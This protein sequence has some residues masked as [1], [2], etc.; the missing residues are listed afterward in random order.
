[1]QD[2]RA[3]QDRESLGSGVYDVRFL[4]TSEVRLGIV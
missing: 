4:E 1:M 3:K 2:P